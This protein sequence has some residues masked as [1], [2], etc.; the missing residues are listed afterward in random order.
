[1]SLRM[2]DWKGVVQ[3]LISQGQRPARPWRIELY[4][5]KDD[6]SET[7]N[8]ASKHPDIVAKMNQVMR[9]QHI[10]SAEFPFP[11]LDQRQ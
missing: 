3:E 7:T 2:G 5:L 1:M 6:I 11:A 8:V 10:P 9:E 4:N